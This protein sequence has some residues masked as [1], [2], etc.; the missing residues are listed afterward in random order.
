MN[1]PKM[2][3]KVNPKTAAS[4]LRNA[5]KLHPKLAIIL[6]S[7]F[8]KTAEEVNNGVKIPYSKLNGFLKTGVPGHNGEAIIGK[9]AGIEVLILNGRT[10]YY[11]GYSFSQITH[12]IRV[13]AEYGIQDLLITNAAGGI[14]SKFK[15]GDFMLFK[16]HLNFIG[17][18][19]LRGLDTWKRERFV[20]LSDVYDLNLAKQI[21]VAARKAKTKLYSGVYCAV[22]GPSYETPAEIRAYAKLGADA[23]GMSTVP[24]AIIARQHGIR[25]GAISCITNLAAGSSKLPLTHQEVLETG[26]QTAKISSKLLSEFARNYVRP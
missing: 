14:N 22:C 19:P 21:R 12:P 15:V 6:G 24:E 18:N 3:G 11:E 2:R 4:A 20:D 17:E 25:V 5:S 7:G 8:Q 26:L 23:V 9:L 1:P 16:D 13:L 10:H